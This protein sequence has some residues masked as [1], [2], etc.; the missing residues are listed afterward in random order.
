MTT[1]PLEQRILTL[2]NKPKYQPL[3]R[4]EMAKT[5]RLHETER[6]KLR[7]TLIHLEKQGQALR[8][9]KNR[10][11][12]GNRVSQ[13]AITGSVRV[14]EKG[15]GLF[16]PDNGG[17]D[18]YIA[19]DDLKCAL[20]E[21]RVSI[22]LF[23][24]AAPAR[25]GSRGGPNAPRFGNREGRVIEVLERKNTDIVGLL[26]RSPCFAFVVPDSLQLVQDIRVSG[27]EKGLEKTPEDY[28]VVVR[29]NEWNDPFK[30]LTG[31][32]IE[33]LGHRDDPNV[34]MQCILRTHG[35]QQHFS[36]EVLAEAAKMP[37][38]LRPEDYENRTDLRKRLTFTI[39]PETARDFDDAISIEKV[40]NGWKLS[41]HIAD[42]AHF[43]PH[44]SLLDKEALHRGN[45]VY[46]VDRVVMMLPTELTTRICSLNP[47]VDRLAHTVEILLDN[48]GQMLSAESCR[49]IIHS[50]ARLTYEQVQ[51]LFD[52]KEDHNIPTRVAKAI[53]MLRPLARAARA[54]RTAAGSLEIN[55]PQI[56]CL[57]DKEGKVASIKK[58]EAKEAYQFIEE[59]MLL[60]NVAVARKL[61][62]AQWPAIHRIHEEP[63]DEQW[64]QMGA[65]LQA[66]GIN[67]LPMTRA[68]INRVMEKI[69]GTPLE[70][71]GSLAVLRNLKR[72]GYSAEPKG[73]FGLAFE[74]YVHFTSPIRRYPDLVIHRLLSALEKKK[75][76]PCR[77]KD[78]E[79]I[80]IHCTLT[81]AE[82]DAAEKESIELRR[83]EYYNNL[84]RQGETGPYPGCIIRI[85]N[86][87]FIV[88]LTDTIQRGLVPFASIT[89]DRYDVNGAKTRATGQRTRRTF[90]IGDIVNVELVNVDLT[91]KFIDFNLEGQKAAAAYTAG[92]KTGPR[93]KK[94][95]LQVTLTGDR[96]RGARPQKRR[97][98]K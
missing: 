29:L 50:D 4:P 18:V 39:D 24:K 2:L 13:Q 28:K 53:A 55:T 20:H 1:I 10:W 35:F 21:D 48:Q 43:V 44:G 98:R 38:E 15:F 40:S 66:L 68:D 16:T 85:L 19:G 17:E 22:E 23:P 41:V 78:I 3:T 57:L 31:T 26:H 33:A 52:G 7:Q 93:S 92:K 87:G 90:K 73:H 27:W 11:A 47:N 75:P 25:R 97:K 46:L 82:A 9:R 54:R 58:G 6:N 56:K 64:A 37:H 96:P 72:A 70:Y 81:E 5:L 71:T 83:V 62:E 69:E 76:S 74:D 63:D 42:V 88:E 60:A 32:V 65:E 67:A 49:S 61:K 36:D 77:S 45:S 84:L 51:A 95:K 14:M 89:G 79:N 94:K 30:P 34:E 86:K 91:R 12:A 8:L 59:C 80:A